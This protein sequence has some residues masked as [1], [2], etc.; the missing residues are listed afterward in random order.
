MTRYTPTTEAERLLALSEK[1]GRVAESLAELALERDSR[2]RAGP[3]GDSHLSEEDVDWVIRARRERAR[4]LPAGL[5]GEPV[6]DMMLHLLHAEI[7]GRCVPAADACLATGLD[8]RI[9][10]R[11]LKAMIENGLVALQEESSDGEEHVEL[12]RE[13]SLGLRRYFREIVEQR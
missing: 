4:Y 8:G 3:S 5:F 7:M 9:G 1:V 10:L 2:E 6:W 13:V 11:W 12:A